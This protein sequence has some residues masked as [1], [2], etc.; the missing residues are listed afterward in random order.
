MPGKAAMPGMPAVVG[1]ADGTV[2]TVV[3]GTAYSYTRYTVAFAAVAE[4]SVHSS[5]PPSGTGIG[6]P[7]GRG[8]CH[9]NTLFSRPKIALDSLASSGPRTAKI[10]T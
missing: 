2:A 3:T 10:K 4:V 6:I 5:L 9:R 7:C 1:Y 8:F